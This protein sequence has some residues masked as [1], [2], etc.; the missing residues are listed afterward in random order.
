MKAIVQ[1]KP[2]V[3]RAGTLLSYGGLNGYVRIDTKTG[4]AKQTQFQAGAGRS[5]L[6]MPISAGRMG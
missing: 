1:N 2:N 6:E 4:A 5:G 3:A